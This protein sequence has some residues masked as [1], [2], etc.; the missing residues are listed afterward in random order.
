MNDSGA[1][2]ERIRRVSSY[3]DVPL[4]NRYDIMRSWH[5]NNAFDLTALKN[6]GS[7][8]AVHRCLG[9]LLAEYIS[10]AA[11]FAEIAKLRQ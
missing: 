6:D 1:L 8:E 2:N 9:R 3:A 5:E 11:S 10:R 7:Y 4:F